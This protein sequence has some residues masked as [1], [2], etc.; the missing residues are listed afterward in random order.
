MLALQ[1]ILM[2]SFPHALAAFSVDDPPSNMR[3][4][5]SHMRILKLDM[6]R[7]SRTADVLARR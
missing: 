1:T 7:H 4:R 3:L 6:E 5:S 2:H